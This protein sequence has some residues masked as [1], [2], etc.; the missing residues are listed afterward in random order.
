MQSGS[1]SKSSSR[2]S[3]LGS[4][5][6]LSALRGENGELDYK[7]MYEQAVADN[8]RLREKLRKS[9]EDL[10]E[11][12]Q[13]LEKLNTVVSWT[14]TTRKVIFVINFL[15]LQTSKNSLSELEKRERRAM[16]RKLSEM[17]EEL[18]VSI[19]LIITITI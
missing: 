2:G 16:E 4:A 9:D 17:E 10:R 6:D 8:D 1:E 7:K 5:S 12:K 19:K 14:K 11:T 3:R 13:T 18:K 15:Y